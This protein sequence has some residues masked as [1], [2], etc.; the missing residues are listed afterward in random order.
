[1]DCEEPIISC[2]FDWEHIFLNEVINY[3]ILQTIF[4]STSLLPLVYICFV[5]C[6]ITQFMV[7]MFD[8][9]LGMNLP[10]LTKLLIFTQNF[11]SGNSKLLKVGG[12]HQK[13]WY[14][15]KYTKSALPFLSTELALCTVSNFQMKKKFWKYTCYFFIIFHF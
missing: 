2:Y 3:N 13:L 14:S 7:D 1:M 9:F 11:F 4:C 15:M 10:L 12:I 6:K 8:M 5:L